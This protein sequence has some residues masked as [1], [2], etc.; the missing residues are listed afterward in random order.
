MFRHQESH[1]SARLLKAQ[2]IAKVSKADHLGQVEELKRKVQQ[3]L[4]KA[5][6]SGER[7]ALAGV[8]E[9]SRLIELVA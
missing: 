9:R 2:K 7:T 6:A 5:E 8:R 1:V 4:Q 3:I